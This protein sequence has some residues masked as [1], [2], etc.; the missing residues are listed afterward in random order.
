MPPAPDLTELDD[1]E[2][3]GCFVE[4]LLL[5]LPWAIASMIGP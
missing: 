4:N 1:I 2:P 3:R 5:H